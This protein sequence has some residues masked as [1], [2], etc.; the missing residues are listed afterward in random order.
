MEKTNFER[1]YGIP[2]EQADDET[3]LWNY[4]EPDDNYLTHNMRPEV[5]AELR[6]RRKLPQPRGVPFRVWEKSGRSYVRWD[7]SATAVLACMAPWE[8]A[9]VVKIERTN[10]PWRGY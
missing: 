9:E 6:R 7:T 4:E 3:L 1:V 10:E 5:E 8:R 2:I